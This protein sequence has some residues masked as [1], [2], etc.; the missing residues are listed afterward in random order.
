[1]SVSDLL[2]FATTPT[3]RRTNTHLRVLSQWL[4]NRTVIGHATRAAAVA[5]VVHAL[6][7]GG[8]LSLTHLGRNLGG[9]GHVKHQIKAV[10]RLL[11][12]R[13]LQI[14]CSGSVTGSTGLSLAL[15]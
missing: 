14:T 1:M 6:L 12:N 3:D 9:I 8:K 2:A 10:D 5:R 15:C 11:G 13:H 4:G 7:M